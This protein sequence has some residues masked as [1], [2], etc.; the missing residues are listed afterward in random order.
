M[1]CLLVQDGD[2]NILIDTGM[3]DKQSDKFKSHFHPHGEH[4]LFDS[5]KYVG[6]EREDITDVLITHFH[7]DHVG[8]ALMMDE[9]GQVSPSFPNATY[10]SNEDHWN[11]AM[12]PNAREQASFLKENFVPLREEGLLKFV[13]VKQGVDFSDNIS[14]NFVYGHTEAMMIPKVRLANGQQMFYCADL[15]PSTA[16]ISLP[17]VM[18]YDIRPLT[19]LEE[20]KK[21][22]KEIIEQDH[23]LFLE[24]DNY[25]EVCS[26]K[27]NEKG[28]V[29][30]DKSWSANEWNVS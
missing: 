30:L 23:L 14:L 1:R 5:L 13:D 24:H 27:T 9:N 17:F 11:W 29:V 4:N 20:R 18:S 28:R 15:L 21:Y 7:F 16:H 25:N 8:G 6:L 10:W 3:G 26:L 19:T 2:R 12:E 22:Y